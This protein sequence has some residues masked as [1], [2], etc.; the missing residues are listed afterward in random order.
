MKRNNGWNR[1]SRKLFADCS[2]RNLNSDYGQTNFPALRVLKKI[3]IL[4]IKTVIVI[5]SSWASHKKW[6]TLPLKSTIRAHFSK[7]I[8]RHLNIYSEKGPHS[9]ATW[10]HFPFAI[11][12]EGH[13]TTPKT[14]NTTPQP[15]AAHI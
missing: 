2:L 4:L 3:N 8:R 1:C 7:S 9:L 15:C 10:Q 11:E 5:T 13:E 14:G 12:S 6:I